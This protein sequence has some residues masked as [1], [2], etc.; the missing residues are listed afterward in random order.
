MRPA[1][2]LFLCLSAFTSSL[3][4]AKLPKPPQIVAEYQVKNKKDAI[5]LTTIYTPT[6][7]GSYRIT[8]V[9]EAHTGADI[10][11]YWA[12]EIQ[13]ESY[14]F[15]CGW[16][17]PGVGSFAFPLRIVANHALQFSTDKP[18]PPGAYSLFITVERV[19]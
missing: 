16:C 15:S 2:L 3:L 6:R 7:N 9:E 18:N 1:T 11:L 5:P 19:Q 8:V 17:I 4:A 13:N 14:Y 10:T 12:D